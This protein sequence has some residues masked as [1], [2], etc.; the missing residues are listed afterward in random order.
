MVTKTK[1]LTLNE[2]TSRFLQS[3]RYLS[4]KTVD[5]YQMCLSGL[6][7][8][9]TKENW[10][11]PDDITREHIG[12]FM[13]YVATEPHRWAGDGK[14][15][16]FNKASAGT[17][18]HYAK[19]VKTFFNWAMD[20]EYI[21][22]S[23]TL[24]MRLPRPNYKEV[25]PYTDEEVTAMLNVCEYDIEHRYRYLGIRNRAIISV[26][27]D[28]GLRLSELAGMKLSELDPK[29]YQVRV[30]GKGAK[31]RVVPLQGEARKALRRY[32]TQAREPSGNEVWKT[33]RGE[34]LSPHSIQ[35]MIDRLKR[36]AGVNSDGG[37]H[38]FRHYFATRCLEN[39]MDMNSLRLLL[40]HAT[41]YMVLRYT[42]F[43]NVQ[44][45]IDEHHQFSPLDSLTRGGNHKRQ[46]D[47]WGWRG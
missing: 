42:K 41:L 40:G 12:D 33:D 15:C 2:L 31:M 32:L 45:A 34:P 19:V 11:D 13:E 35:V 17:V 16:T 36:R 10:P 22:K 20:E 1:S 47:G 44:R 39:G 25:E 29:L 38:R 21:E 14:R 18:H 8:F 43:V 9:A 28:T 7:W 23:P 37:I 3:R 26:F 4:P 24:G 46:D 5:Y 30:M 6:G 27:I